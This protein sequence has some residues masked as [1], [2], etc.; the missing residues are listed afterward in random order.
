MNI[1]RWILERGRISCQRHSYTSC[2]DTE[3]S[4][5]SFVRKVKVYWLTSL[6]VRSGHN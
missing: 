4:V 2:S 3:H 1:Q 6:G 5:K